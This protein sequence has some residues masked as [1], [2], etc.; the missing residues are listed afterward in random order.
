MVNRYYSF[1]AFQKDFSNIPFVPIFVLIVNLIAFY[2][3]MKLSVF[4][5]HLIVFNRNIARINAS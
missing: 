4:Y 3:K 1:K 5:R 2:A